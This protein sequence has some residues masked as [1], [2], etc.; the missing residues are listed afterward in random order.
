MIE[1]IDG[2]PD[3]DPTFHS[4]VQRALEDCVPGGIGDDWFQPQAHEL[5]DS[6]RSILDG[7]DGAMIWSMCEDLY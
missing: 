3:A 4:Y 6:K 5:A 1:V 2:N 7:G